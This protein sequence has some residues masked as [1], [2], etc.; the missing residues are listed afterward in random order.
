MGVGGAHVVGGLVGFGTC[1]RVSV[2]L[3]R[4]YNHLILFS[5]IAVDSEY[6]YLNKTT[7]VALVFNFIALDVDC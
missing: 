2:G 7:L 1:R 5:D 6:S 4:W 3:G